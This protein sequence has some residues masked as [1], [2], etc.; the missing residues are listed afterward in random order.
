MQSRRQRWGL[1]YP[2]GARMMSGQTSRHEELEAQLAEFVGMPDAY[3]IKLWLP[4]YAF[5]HR[6]FG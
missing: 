3:L 6:C 4:G 1:A 5:Y 2:M